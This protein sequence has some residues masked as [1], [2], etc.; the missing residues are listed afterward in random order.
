M[1]TAGT[2]TGCGRRGEL[3]AIGRGV[4]RCGAGGG[5]VTTEPGDGDDAQRGVGGIHQPVGADD[6]PP[7][8]RRGVVADPVGGPQPRVGPA[9]P[10]PA[11]GPA[12]DGHLVCPVGVA[13]GRA[14]VRPRRRG[15]GP[16]VAASGGDPTHAAGGPAGDRHVCHR[17][18]AVDVAGC[19]DHRNA[20]RRSA[21]GVSR[22][23]ARHSA[24]RVRVGGR[25]IL[26]RHR[27][28]DR[29]RRRGPRPP[30]G[31]RPGCGSVAHG[32][33]VHHQ[34]PGGPDRRRGVLGAGGGRGGR[35]GPA[36]QRRQRTTPR[37]A[38]RPDLRTVALPQP[39]DR[40]A[41]IRSDDRI[42]LPGPARWG[43]RN[44]RRH[45]AHRRRCLAAGLGRCGHPHAVSAHRGAQRR[46]HRH[47][48]RS[49]PVCRLDVGAVGRR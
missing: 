9:S 8:H 44:K 21:G 46:H 31:T 10:R 43:T 12:E 30:G 39:R 4:Y 29:D 11:G 13:A 1:V 18:Q 3:P 38:R 48:H 20:A 22:R 37:P 42:Q 47:R 14:R 33:L 35:A 23:G 7:G 27:R 28:A 32:G 41:R 25:R 19:R 5:A 6:S 26:R 49:A 15:P 2:R 17:R 24:D 45:L 16:G 36:D 40:A 34:V